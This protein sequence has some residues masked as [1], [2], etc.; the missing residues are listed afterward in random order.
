MR[1]EQ[2]RLLIFNA[3]G[4]NDGTGLR[5]RGNS[6]GACGSCQ[7]TTYAH[8]RM[9]DPLTWERS[10]LRTIKSRYIL[11]VLGSREKIHLN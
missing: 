10:G 5:G 9:G 1:R 2:K 6:A 4:E 7:K 11:D 3:R 8:A